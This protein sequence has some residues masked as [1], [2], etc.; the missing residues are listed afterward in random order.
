MKVRSDNAPGRAYSVEAQ[1]KT[2][3]RVLVRFY[4]NVEPFTEEMDGESVSGFEYDEH[5]L[6]LQNSGNID[7]YVAQHYAALLARAKAGHQDAVA[8][9]TAQ[10]S[11]L[12]DALCEKDAADDER[13]TAIEEALCE[14]DSLINGGG[15]Q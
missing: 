6:E 10:M 11:A 3:G 12:E 5:R 15:E 14:L 13:L 7:E 9:L 8:A 2:P 4:E 1:P